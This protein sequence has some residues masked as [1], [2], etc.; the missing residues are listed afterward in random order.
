M[1]TAISGQEEDLLKVGLYGNVEPVEDDTVHQWKV[2]ALDK[3]TGEI[4]W[5][6]LAHEGVPKI[7]RHTKASH[8]NSSP[9]TDG[10]YVVAFFGSEGLYC[11]RAKDG[12]LVWIP[13]VRI[14]YWFWH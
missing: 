6:R 1:T 12:K 8:A 4:L 3:K 9:A 14:I 7:K 2:Y 10:K 13:W 5:E 11:Y